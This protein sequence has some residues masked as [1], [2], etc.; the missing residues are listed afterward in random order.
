MTGEKKKELL[1]DCLIHMCW[2]DW[3][4]SCK[5]VNPYDKADDEYRCHLR[6]SEGRTPVDGDEWDMDTAFQ[7]D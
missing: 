5:F 2:F 4:D 3:C 7:D 1:K 6:D